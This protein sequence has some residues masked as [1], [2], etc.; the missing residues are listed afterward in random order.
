MPGTLLAGRYRI[1][2]LIGRG[3][4]GEVYRSDDLTL[5]QPVALKFL[6]ESI[7]ENEA[8]LT[9]FR[10]EVRIARQVSHPNVCRVYDVGEI[11]GHMYLSMEYVD[12]EDLAS[13]LRRIGRLPSD[14]GI[15][16]AR[17]LCAGLAAAHEKGVLHRDLK[18]GNVMLDARGQVL[19]T[20]FG[21]AGLADQIAGAEV[22]NGTPA[23][24]APE[25]LSGKEVT[26]RS[27]IY[28]LGLVLYEI[29]TGRRP[30]EAST[31]AELVRAQTDTTPTS[32]TS[33]VRDL[34]PAVERVILRCLDPEPSRRPSSALAVA[35]ALPG[36]DPLAAAL[37]AGETP[38]PQMVA[39]AGEGLGLAPKTAMT[40]LAF[41]ILSLAAYYALAVRRSA[42]ERIHLDYSPEVLSQKA[43]DVIQGLG[44][45]VSAIDNDYGFDWD[46]KFVEYIE[47]ND[48][49]VPDWS[50]ILSQR[51][52]PFLFWY[53]QSPYPLTADSY[54]DDLLTPGIVDRGD[55]APILSGMI[56]LQLDPQGRLLYLE[57]IPDQQLQ[58]AK[59]V[60]QIDWKPLFAAAGLDLSKFQSSEPLRTWLATSDTRAAWTGTWPESNRPLR[61]EAASLRGKPLA[62]ALISP[63]TGTGRAPQGPSR[64][65]W[66]QV[67]IFAVILVAIFF[68]GGWL[69]RRSL[70]QGR[71]DREGAWRLA[72]WIGGV[73][74][75]LWICRAHFTASMG[76]FGMAILA[77]CT[78][79]F[80]GFTVYIMYI[81][82]EPHVRRRWPQTLI[83]WT[84]ILTGHWRDPIVG[85]DVLIGMAAGI[86]V[87]ALSQTVDALTLGSNLPPTLGPTAVLLGLRSTL[88][89]CLVS[90][91][92]GIRD[93]LMFF[94][95]LFLLRVFL[96]NEWLASMVL[97][98]IFSAGDVFGSNHPVIDGLETLF[99]YGLVA[100]IA[101]R[102]GLLALGIY[103]FTN[104]L[105][106]GMQTTLHA[107]AWYLGND[108]F[109]LA[110]VLGLAAWSCH[111]SMAGQ[112]LWKESLLES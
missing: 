112:K 51:P 77:V 82:L 89:V 108:L 50:K 20:D 41:V 98:I 109:L 45:D 110:F 47:K 15:E 34:D 83:S 105:V 10:N 107:S 72:S 56:G 21:L 80:Y 60:P 86:G 61:V 102:F 12:G 29:F 78:A 28:A 33:L 91:P 43:R 22:R 73:Q 17:K 101:W 65:A 62:F 70:K 49:P 37:A 84:A 95:L 18:P 53:R 93:T 68:G 39:A 100:V 74:L 92:H 38:S 13:L 11:D 35:A 9:R 96:R 87:H 4:M 81:A 3:G 1:V 48:K 71:G 40:L 8:A 16:I 14:K 19:L 75:A 64:G 57:R 66:G 85:R 23:Y 58:P 69:A 25:Q 31:L 30:F 44:I 27:D 46:N 42:L 88:T 54:H 90:L 24:M 76:T 63:W 59:D 55:P 111:T 7:G 97:A 104:S 32:L 5:E 106:A 52:T 67:I 6:P 103:I 94:L 36:G 2:S 79:V 99:A 26:A